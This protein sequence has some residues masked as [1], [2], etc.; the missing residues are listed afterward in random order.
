M[1]RWIDLLLL[2]SGNNDARKTNFAQVDEINVWLRA[3]HKKDNPLQ[4]G[5]IFCTLDSPAG[6]V[7]IDEAWAASIDE[8]HYESLIEKICNVNWI[9]KEHA[10]LMVRKDPAGPWEIIKLFNQ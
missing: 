5:G 2:L 9:G 10:L 1:N 8:K 7:I 4:M 6:Y 3:E